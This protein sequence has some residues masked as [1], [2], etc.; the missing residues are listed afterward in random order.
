MDEIEAGRWQRLRALLDR[1]IDLDARARGAW[2][3]ALSADDQ[4][5]RP[6]LE[7]LL[8]R[9]EAIRDVTLSTAT[10]LLTLALAD[11]SAA[12]SNRAARNA[13]KAIDDVLAGTLEDDD[14]DI[15]RRWLFG[16]RLA[17]SK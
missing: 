1:A 8:A 7:A 10:A 16:E 5:L 13:G 12:E 3:D 9:H 17:T 2:L 4:T 11:H 14:D 15:V 6:E